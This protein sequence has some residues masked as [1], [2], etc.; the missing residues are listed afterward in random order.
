MKSTYP[1]RDTGSGLAS[2]GKQAYSVVGQ[3]I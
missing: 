2:Q 3:A 1:D